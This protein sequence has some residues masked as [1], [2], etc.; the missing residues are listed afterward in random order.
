MDKCE[1]DGRKNVAIW[2]VLQCIQRPF[3]RQ[4]NFSAEKKARVNRLVY[5]LFG[6]DMTSTGR[7]SN[8]NLKHVAASL[9][10]ES[11][12]YTVTIH[13]TFKRIR[14]TIT[15]GMHCVGPTKDSQH[16]KC[17]YV[18]T[19]TVFSVI[20]AI[21]IDLPNIGYLK[22]PIRYVRAYFLCAS[23][24]FF[25]TVLRSICRSECILCQ[26]NLAHRWMYS[27]TSIAK[28]RFA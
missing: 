3:L 21:K 12:I 17:M 7:F 1:L 6:L 11:R 18:R 13:Y 4:Q 14:C 24:C 27:C 28:C 19:C 26:W 9:L 23:I 8:A 22:I 15:Y 5:S 20:L 25:F 16:R 10:N 2:I